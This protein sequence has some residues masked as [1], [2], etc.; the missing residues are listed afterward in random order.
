[1]TLS[2]NAPSQTSYPS[3]A[4]SNH[5]YNT[6]HKRS[7]YSNNSSYSAHGN[8]AVAKLP[9]PAPTPTGLSQPALPSRMPHASTPPPLVNA[10]TG[11]PAKGVAPPQQTQPP[12]PQINLAA[13]QQQASVASPTVTASPKLEVPLASPTAGSLTSPSRWASFENLGLRAPKLDHRKFSKHIVTAYR[14]LGFV[15]LTIIVLA[16]V[17]YLITTAFFYVSDSWV[18]PMAIS[19]TDEKVVS[20]QSQLSERQTTRDRTAAELD[21]AERAIEVQQAFQAEFAKAI[22]SDLDGRKAALARMYELANQAASTRSQIKRSNSAYASA[23]QKRMAEEW[24]AGLIDRDQMLNGKFQ[25]AQISGSNLSL[26]E[27][28]AEYETRAEDLEAQTRSLDA[29]LNDTNAETTMSYDVLRIKQEFEASRLETQRAIQ[30]RDMLRS[31]L[32]R[33]DKLLES[34]KNSSYLKAMADGAHV[35]FVPYS[36]LSDMKK[37]APLYGCALTM[38]FCKKVGEVM[39]VLPGEVTFKHPNRD[40]QLRGQMVEL[41]LDSQESATDDVLFVGGRPLL[42]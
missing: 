12:I 18:V 41:K 10:P 20:L 22:K 6:S 3:S 21:Q 9:T 8:A 2:N 38:V 24:R 7:P 31:A 11:T 15:I 34:L 37:G 27:R 39:E 1:M 28:Q 4:Q 14:L 35:A 42:L 5:G 25:V 19:P 32:E 26:L 30:N 23:Q 16:L 33:E 29:L 13:L 40:K 36:N 17:S